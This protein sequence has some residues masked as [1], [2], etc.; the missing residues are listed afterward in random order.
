M[1]FKWVGTSPVSFCHPFPD[2]YTIPRS[3][4]IAIAPLM[5]HRNEK[6]YPNPMKFDPDRFLPENCKGRHAYDYIP[7]SAG[8]RNCI[9]QFHSVLLLIS[10]TFRYEICPIR[11]SGDSQLA[12]KELPLQYKYELLGQRRLPGDYS[13]S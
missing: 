11:G 1:T 9:G 8:P 13:S 12:D 6:I 3:S 10:T 7:F 5:I 2:G 4:N